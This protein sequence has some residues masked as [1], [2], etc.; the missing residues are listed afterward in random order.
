LKTLTCTEASTCEETSEGK[1]FRDYAETAAIGLGD[2]S[3]Y[4]FTGDPECVGSRPADRIGTAC[5]GITPLDLDGTGEVA[6]GWATLDSRKP[7]RD[8]VIACGRKGYPDVKASGKPECLTPTEPSWVIGGHRQD[9]TATCVSKSS[10]DRLGPLARASQMSQS[11]SSPGASLPMTMKS[12]AAGR[13]VAS[14]QACRLA[15]R[16]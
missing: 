10:S 8:F 15:F 5:M 3:E 11:P 14:A 13:H 1:S 2:R 7:F 9:V 4:K 12:T 6:A 16:G